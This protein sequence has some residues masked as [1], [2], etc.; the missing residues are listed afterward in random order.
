[1]STHHHAAVGEKPT[2]WTACSWLRIVSGV[3]KAIHCGDESDRGRITKDVVA[4]HAADFNKLVQ[5][6]QLDLYEP[7]ISQCVTW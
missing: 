4:F 1:M 3:L 5:L 2:T 6:L 7:P